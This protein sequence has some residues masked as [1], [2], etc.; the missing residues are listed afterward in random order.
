MKS[1][2]YR[3]FFL[4]GLACCLASCM[5]PL[6]KGFQALETSQNETATEYFKEVEEHPKMGASAQYGLAQI[7]LQEARDLQDYQAAFTLLTFQEASTQSL[8]FRQRRNLRKQGWLPKQNKALKKAWQD[9][10]RSYLVDTKDLLSLDTMLAIWEGNRTQRLTGKNQAAIVNLRKDLVEEAVRNAYDYARLHSLFV[11][12][13]EVIL[14]NRFLLAS[15]LEIRVQNAFI[16]EFG[17]TDFGRFLEE[18]PEHFLAIDCWKK[19]FVEAAQD[20]TIVGMLDFMF[21]YPLSAFNQL[22]MSNILTADYFSVPPIETLSLTQQESYAVIT[23][24]HYLLQRLGGNIPLDE[25]HHQRLLAYIEK[26]APGTSPYFIMQYA[27]GRYLDQKKWEFAEQLVVHTQPFFPDEQPENCNTFYDYYSGKQDWYRVAIPIVHRPD[28]DINIRP[29]QALNSLV[30]NE[31]SPVISSDGLSLYFAGSN[32]SDNIKGDDVFVSHRHNNYWTAPELVPNLSGADNFVP[33]SL[34]SDERA[35]LVFVNGKLHL[36]EYTL[37]GWSTPEP[38]PQEINQMPW[39]GR[40]SFAENGRVLILSVTTEEQTI[41]EEADTD[42]Y[43]V[44]KNNLGNWEK[45]F[46]LGEIINTPGMERSPFIH[47]DGKT[48]YFS[49]NGHPGLGEMDVFFATRL[50]NSWKRWSK[51]VNMGKE[52]NN[53]DDD[54]GYNFAVSTVGK[55]AYFSVLN[56]S[57]RFDLMTSGVPQFIRPEK[58]RTLKI[59]LDLQE[60]QSI[61]FVMRDSSGTIVGRANAKPDGALV[62][63][64]PQG[65]EGPFSLT[66]TSRGHLMLPMTLDL[67]EAADVVTLEDT[68][69]V[70]SKAFI[71][72]NQLNLELASVYFERDS[73]HLEA[74]SLKAIKLF[75]Q[76]LNGWRPII[77]VAGYTDLQGAKRYNLEL[78]QKRAD[79]VKRA[80][81]DLG[82]P[83]EKIKAVGY[84]EREKVETG[85]DGDVQS[86]RTVE[87]IIRGGEKE[88][89]KQK[90]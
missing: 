4:V 16:Q 88:E 28:E 76:A 41:D 60:S 86:N 75:H 26:S 46:S 42:I 19:E 5:G 44:K 25:E 83:P 8:P 80:F 61:P 10:L 18:N 73:F 72:K 77:E 67:S 87:I 55:N 35:L 71:V 11:N 90:E 63:V 23:E 1:P 53:I 17:W 47:P 66:T 20:P 6:K 30:G 39:I 7:A 27:L 85:P 84:G 2:F 51:P 78:S 22:A 54:W 57:G 21:T 50:D 49:S 74:P 33:L 40:A 36:S 48:L 45:P 43:V 29:V 68:L 82:Y 37:Q 69:Q 32:R 58:L 13:Q 81:L 15:D 65:A 89:K 70:Y 38:L 52:I 64:V 9:S 3:S 59:Y 56:N 14:Q 31:F 79:A 34:T 62:M 24:G 12:H